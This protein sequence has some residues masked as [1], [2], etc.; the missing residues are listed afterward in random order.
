MKM[1]W[2]ILFE[3]SR[4]TV[5]NRAANTTIESTMVLLMYVPLQHGTDAACMPRKAPGDIAS[6][7]I[8]THG[9]N[10]HCTWYEHKHKHE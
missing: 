5:I 2:A 10:Y 8:D 4:R 9:V 6:A 1:R 7:N 3:L